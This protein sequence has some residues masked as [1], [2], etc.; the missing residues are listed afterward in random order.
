MSEFTDDELVDAGFCSAVAA[1]IGP[2]E[3]LDY[4]RVRIDPPHGLAKIT[5]D[6]ETKVEVE[7]SHTIPMSPDRMLDIGFNSLRRVAI[8]RVRPAKPGEIS[9]ED[10][11]KLLVYLRA[12]RRAVDETLHGS[13][14]GRPTGILSPRG[15]AAVKRHEA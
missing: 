6:D 11:M 13:S 4:V 8:Y 3:L 5:F 2:L 15:I 9:P 7:L 10:A 12:A 1:R 14:P